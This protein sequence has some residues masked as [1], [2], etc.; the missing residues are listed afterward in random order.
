MAATAEGS[1]PGTRLRLSGGRNGCE[2]RVEVYY[3]SSW[4]TVCDDSWDLRDAQVVCRQLGC[5]QPTD[6]PGNARFGL[7]SGT[8]FLDDVQCRGDEPSL[9]MCTHNGWG[10]HNCGHTEDASVICE[11]AWEQRPLRLSGGRN[12]C[13]GRVEVY[14]G[15]SWGTVC[16]DSWDLRDAQVVCRQLGCGQP[17]D[18]PGNARFGLGSGTIFL[19]DV[20]CRGDEPSLPMCRHNGWGIHNC[21]H[22]EDASVIC[23]AAHP[24]TPAEWPYT[25]GT[26]LRLSGGRNGC[27]GR[28]EV[29]YGSS[30]G[31]VCDDSWDLRDAQ[32]VCRQ[33]G[34]GQ[35]TDAPGNARF[36]LGSGTI[37]LDDVQCRGD[38]PSL[39][40]CTHNGWGIHN[41][42]H[43]E[44]ASVICEAAHPTTPAEWPYTTGTRLRLSGGRNGCEGRVEVYYGSSWGTVCDDSWDLRDAQVVCRQLGCGQPTDAPGNARFGLGSGTIFLDDVQCRGDEPSL[45]MCR[46]NGWGIH[47][48]GHTEDASVICEGAWEQRPPAVTQMPPGGFWCP[49]LGAATLTSPGRATVQ[50]RGWGLLLQGTGSTGHAKALLL[51]TERT[52]GSPQSQV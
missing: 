6:A 25:T 27:E 11:G 38:E 31:T 50:W 23:E 45:P 8:I 34:C 51:H 10:I 2:G 15:S 46:H 20:Q 13:E 26:R 12:G 7:G 16:D 36:G 42:G 18:A 22:T 5:G 4:G 29:Y 48:C 28:V 30:W 14:Y 9:P 37:F 32:V 43:T 3:G 21:G 40:M 52:A 19:D 39:P 1:T 41:C 35:P 17:T 33:L 24:T 47:N 44:D 49:P